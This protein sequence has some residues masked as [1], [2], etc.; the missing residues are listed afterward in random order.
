[1]ICFCVKNM[2]LLNQAHYAS[3]WQLNIKA[4]RKRLALHRKYLQSLLAG[5]QLLIQI[6]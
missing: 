4:G 3:Y 5:L 6:H 2:P 1:M